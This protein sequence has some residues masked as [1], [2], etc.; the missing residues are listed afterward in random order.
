MSTAHG[1]DVPDVDPGRIAEALAELGRSDSARRALFQ[2]LR[3]AEAGAPSP[4]SFR[5]LVRWPLVSAAL[6]RAGTHRVTLRDGL[7]FEVALQSRIER[8]LL[9]S[10]DEHPDHVWEPQTT[11]LLVALAAEA[12][13]VI[14]GGAYIGDQALPIARALAS[15]RGR[16]VHAF[17]PMRGPFDQL[18]RNIAL[19]S[20]GNVV[21]R[22]LALWDRPGLELAVDGPAALASCVESGLPEVVEHAESI[23]IDD[24]VRREHL[25]RVRLITLDLEGGEERALRGAEALLAEPAGVAPHVV[26]EVHRQYADWSRGLEHVPSVAL[27]LSRGYSAYA[28]RDYHDNVS[29]A[30][31]PVEII[32]LDAVHLEGPPHGFNV[33]AVKSPATIARLGLE[34]VRNVSPKLLR[35]RD[36][37]LHHPLH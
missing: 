28:I 17:E 25:D 16:T 23:T 31:R 29:T 6:D 5:E 14:V 19:N 10:A 1:K 9:L 36:P 33:L 22:R 8:A 11:K 13:H 24:Y 26:F 32:P 18:L 3:E 12:Q 15:D 37:R 27:V 30:G 4:A 34:L 35:D 20:L 7:V 2:L 21:T